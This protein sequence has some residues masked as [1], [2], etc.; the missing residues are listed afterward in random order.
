MI[1]K[2]LTKDEPSAQLV[3]LPIQSRFDLD[4]PF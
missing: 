3:E 4:N 2:D 1:S